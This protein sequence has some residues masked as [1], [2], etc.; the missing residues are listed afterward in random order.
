MPDPPED[1]DVLV[2]GGGPAGS[3]AATFLARRGIDVV[4]LEKSAHP[5][6]HIGESLLPANLGLFERLGIAAEVAAIG[7]HKPG[8]E[9]VSDDTGRSIAFPFAL[10][11]NRAFT[12][13]FH[14]KRAD[15]DALLFANATRSGARAAERTR[16]T[17]MT[18]APPG[19]RARITA[20]E[21]DR[22]RVLAPRYVLD[23][24]GRDTFLAGRLRLAEA[25]KR[26]ST[27]AMYAH[28]RGVAPRPGEMPGS[29]S[30][31]LTEDGWFWMIPLPDDVMSVGFVGN[32]SAFKNRRD[33]GQDL[34]EERLRGSATLSSRMAGA[35]LVSP[36]AA[37]ANYSYRARSAGGNGYM[38]I[39]DAFAFVDPMFSSGVLMAMT[40]GELGAEVA[41]TWLRNPARGVAA[42]RR[43][44][45]RVCRAMDKLN[46]LIYRINTPVLRS[47]FLSPRNTFRMRDGLV[48]MLA[49]NLGFDR[50]AVL[51]VLAFKAVYHTL[52]LGN[53][54]G[55]GWSVGPSFPR[56]QESRATGTEL[57]AHGLDSRFR[58]K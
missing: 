22:V 20:R 47:L 30:V 18:F 5:R 33:S 41:A 37:T 45:R 51:P 54:L 28:F 15:F 23:A 57:G 32:Q 36:V 27:A 3:T 10:S 12:H 34:L 56:K 43:A 24:S 13:S 9:F 16:V 6:F 19:G 7:V 48:S 53:R 26:N 38:L 44:E 31:H 11:L 29:I 17:D 42:A 55:L 1:C 39:G 46:W 50:R 8:A 14:V 4:L 21:E 52:N 35:E 40:G 25:N 2:I 49:G 58:G